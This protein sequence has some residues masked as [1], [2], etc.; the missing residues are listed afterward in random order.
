MR[1]RQTICTLAALGLFI[2]AAGLVEK[3]PLWSLVLAAAMAAAMYI[4]RLGRRRVTAEDIER[5]CKNGKN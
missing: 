1:T 2:F 3:Q 5:R 4:G